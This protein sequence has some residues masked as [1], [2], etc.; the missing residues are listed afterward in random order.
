M[1]EMHDIDLG[2]SYGQ[3]REDP[4]HVQ[5]LVLNQPKLVIE[6]SNGAVNF[7]KAMDLMPAHDSSSKPVKLIIDEYFRVEE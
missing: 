1:F 2:V 5:S 7:K 4:I 3:L 6:Q